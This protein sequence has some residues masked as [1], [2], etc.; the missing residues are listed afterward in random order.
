[1]KFFKRNW[2][3]L[4]IL[5]VI[6]LLVFPQTRLPIQVFMQRLI[7]FSPS[8]V[9]QEQQIEITD[10]NWSLKTLNGEIVSFTE[11]ENQV[12]IVNF[13]ATWCPPCIAEMP[14]FQQL[15]EK[16]GDEVR[17]YF[18]TSEDPSLIIDF[19]NKK[20]YTFP[21][22]IQTGSLPSY[23]SVPS[24]PKTYVL[25][26]RAKVVVEKTGVADWNTKK[27]HRL[28]DTLLSEKNLI[29]SSIFGVQLSP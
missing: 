25:S 5:I 6:A 9:Q 14:S 8:E 12:V 17:F 16:Y 3:N 10:Y 15:Y 20:K 24:L 2:G 1:M 11:S 23:F 22:Y 28:L 21:V 27:V 26:S 29:S 18:I 7:A 4:A 13:W 19:M